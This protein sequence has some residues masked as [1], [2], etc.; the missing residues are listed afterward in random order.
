MASFLLAVS[1]VRGVQP[2]HVRIMVVPQRHHEHN[3]L[4]EGFFHGPQTTF[5]Q[6]V[7]S[8]LGVSSPVF[9]EIIR[10]RVML[11]SVDSVHGMLN[12]FAILGVKLLHLAQFAAVGSIIS[13]ELRGDCHWF[14]GV[15][16]EI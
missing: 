7:C 5:L 4:L 8:I 10:Y 1:G 16:F 3:T 11:I 13:D 2:E 9:A 6:V 14:G 15:N 12:G